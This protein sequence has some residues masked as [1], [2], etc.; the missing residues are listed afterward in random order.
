MKINEATGEELFKLLDTSEAGLTEEEATRRL[1][2]FGFN[3]IKEIRRVPLFLK[4]LNQF[5]HFLAI[6][7]WLAAAL[8]FVSDYIHPGE[9]MRHLGFAIIGV[10]FIN[11]VFA[12]VQ[13]YRAEKSIEKLKLMLPFYV[14]VIREGREKQI[15]AREVV[16]GDLIILSEGDKIPADARVIESNFL[17]VNNAP[18]T[19]ESLPVV[20]THETEKGELIESKNIA[21][22]GAE[23]VSGNGKAVVFAT[24]MSTEFGRI[25]HLTETVHTEPTPLQKE[26]SRTSK[27]IAFVATLIGLIFF[28]VGHTIG[29]SFWEN[30]IFAIGVIVA[31]VPEGMLP[32]VTLSLAI[33]S[34]RMLK[35]NALIK[36]LTSVEALGSITVICTDKTGTITQNKME[37]KK[38]WMLK[39]NQETEKMLLKIAYLCNNAKFF[40]N[41]YK[42]D[43]TEIALLKY[44]KENMGDIQ[45]E[46]LSEI[47]FDFERKRMTTVNIIDGVRLSLTKGAVETVLSLCKYAL[48]NGHKTELTEEINKQI[49]LA[50]HSLM[51]E[52]LRVLCFAYSEVEPEKDMLFVGLAGLEDPPR[53]EVSEAIRKCHEAGIKIILITGDA[54]R[55][56]LAIAKE[57]E[58]IK[59]NPVIIEAEEFHKMTDLE[60]REKLKEREILFTRMTPKDKLR[61]VTL[62][63][64]SGERVAVT[65]DGVNDAPALKKADIGVAMGSGTD[66][67]KEAGEIILL[68]DNFATI[69]NAIE[70]GRAIYENI[71]KFISYFFTSNIAELIPYIAYAVFRIPL[72]LTIMQIL[73][74][75][76]G[77]DILPGLA[78][79]AEKPTKEVMK[80][81]PRG[82]NERLLNI[83]LLLR[84]FLILGPIEAMAGLFGY[85]YVLKSGGWQWGEALS[86]NNILYMQ[87]TTACLTGIVL[88][89]VANGFVSRSFKESV[90]SLG[91]FSNKLLLGGILFELLLQ[92]FIV[93]HP[94]GNSIF[95]T[96]PIPLN[97]WLILIPF[98]VFLFA[99]EETRKFFNFK[100]T[101]LK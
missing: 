36:K 51:D 66:V 23:L 6:I 29:R 10:I 80:K 25:A 56:A 101:K 93:Y 21:F 43:P 5:T 84:V 31:L 7:L 89:Q 100:F 68:D 97:I 49:N 14:K 59:N 18:L 33:G 45:F 74:I 42:G 15:H 4:F 98:A 41:Q 54:S 47:P 17:T 26:I 92:I 19:G 11:A 13:E 3:E 77:T 55:T 48:I 46:R 75:D 39:Q 44:A 37:V 90:F 1:S 27:F 86:A 35:R 16:P 32:T 70:E 12:F 24:G 96:Y 81:P 78:L 94:I 53:P 76:L 60:L 30:F 20:L 40:E 71:R 82:T 79:G 88:A 63:Q 91:I 62:L 61:I 72:P 87:A 22:A 69:V 65:G 38:L 52:G 64:E 9:G 73:A 85:F 50:Y 83:K 95:S 2:H 99:V 28:I 58:L 34:Q 67:A 57:I 8:A